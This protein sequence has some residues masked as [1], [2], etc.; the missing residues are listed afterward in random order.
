VPAALLRRAGWPERINGD[1]GVMTSY[2]DA[3]FPSRAIEDLLLLC[4]HELD[5]KVIKGLVD[6]A[7]GADPQKP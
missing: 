2:S 4:F 7:L 5:S 3:R 1:D 6:I